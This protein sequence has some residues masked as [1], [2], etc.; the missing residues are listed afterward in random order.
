MTPFRPLAA[1]ALLALGGPAAFAG[2]VYGAIGLPGVMGG[3]ANPLGES[4]TLRADFATIGSRTRTSTEEGIDYNLKLKANRFALFGDWYPFSGTF[5]LTGGVT[6]ND[7][8]LTLAATGAGG[9]LTIG[10]NSYTTTAADRLDGV[11]KFP[12]ATPY[13]GFGWG[14]QSGSGLRFSADVG[15]MFGKA[16]LSYTVSGPLASQV[17]QADID[18][19]TQELRDGVAKIRWVPQL[20]FGIGYSF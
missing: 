13:L 14:H 9:T 19:E 12:S 10:D 20:S 4:F 1:C 17:T 15:A 3:Y 18:K 16:K 5:R 11:V 8:K 2:E 6:A 7:Y